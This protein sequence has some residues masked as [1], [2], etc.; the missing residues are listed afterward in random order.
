MATS[1]GENSTS[2]WRKGVET[3]Q[4]GPPPRSARGSFSRGVGGG[5]SIKLIERGLGWR[6]ERKSDKVANQVIRGVMELEGGGYSWAPSVIKKTQQPSITPP[7]S[8]T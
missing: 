1:G 4:K 6:W 2:C 7:P 8:R 3:S 5:M